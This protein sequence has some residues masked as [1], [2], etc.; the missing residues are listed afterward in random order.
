MCRCVHEGTAIV[1]LILGTICIDFHK[2]LKIVLPMVLFTLI[3]KYHVGIVGDFIS[4]FHFKVITLQC[5]P[6]I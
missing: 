6:L 4:F 5:I 1:N 3:P 2:M